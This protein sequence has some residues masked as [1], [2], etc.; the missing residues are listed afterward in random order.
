M[1]QVQIF[2]MIVLLIQAACVCIGVI[3]YKASKKK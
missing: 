3:G 1:T 2:Q